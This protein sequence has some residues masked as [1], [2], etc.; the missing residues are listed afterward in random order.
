M[1]KYIG[2]SFFSGLARTLQSPQE[3]QKLVDSIV[4]VDE[5]TGKTSLNIPVPDKESVVNI[6]NMVGKLL[7]GK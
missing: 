1:K 3:T 4:K 6:L 2:K 7:G 5:K